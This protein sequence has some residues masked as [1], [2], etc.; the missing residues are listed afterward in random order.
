MS[1]GALPWR[2]LH[3]RHLRGRHGQESLRD[4]PETLQWRKS[5]ERLQIN[6]FIGGG[7]I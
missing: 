3:E 4:A 1:S 5:L 7:N 2:G 6:L